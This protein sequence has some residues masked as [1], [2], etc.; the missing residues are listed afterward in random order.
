GI[1][2]AFDTL[3]ARLNTLEAA[4]GELLE[5][6]MPQR[7]SEDPDGVRLNEQ[8]RGIEP[9]DLDVYAVRAHRPANAR[10]AIRIRRP[11]CGYPRIGVTSA[12]HQQLDH[13]APRRR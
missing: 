4:H 12:L 10:V 13:R 8:P 11:E 6:G 1:S 2:A 7:V 9:R 5:G 3:E